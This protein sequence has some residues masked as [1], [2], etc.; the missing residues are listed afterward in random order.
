VLIAETPQGRGVVGVVDGY[1]PKGLEVEAD[2][3]W[4]KKFL[5]QIGYKL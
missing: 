2:I 4:R 5:R 1:P 3:E